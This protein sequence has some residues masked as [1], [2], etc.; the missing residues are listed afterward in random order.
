MCNGSGKKRD[1]TNLNSSILAKSHEIQLQHRIPSG[2][3]L[4]N[5]T[6]RT[7]TKNTEP[8]QYGQALKS[9]RMQFVMDVC[10]LIEIKQTQNRSDRYFLC[11]SSPFETSYILL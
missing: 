1:S 7:T 10:L 5:Q 4:A 2:I 11:A 3:L 6:N 9:M 8:K